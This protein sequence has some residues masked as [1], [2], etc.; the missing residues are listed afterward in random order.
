MQTI[1]TIPTLMLA[2][3][4]GAAMIL[5]SGAALARNGGGDHQE[6]S[7]HQDHSGMKSGN[8]NGS[9]ARSGKHSDGT[10]TRRAKAKPSPAPSPGAARLREVRHPQGRSLGAVRRRGGHRP[11]VSISVAIMVPE[12]RSTSK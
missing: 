3:S 7:D 10:P 6:H 12:L 5:V 11:Q 4:L 2:A 8:G 1:K 9:A